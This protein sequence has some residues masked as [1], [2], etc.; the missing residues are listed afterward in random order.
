MDSLEAF[1]RGRDLTLEAHNRG[2]PINPFKAEIIPLRMDSSIPQVWQG[3]NRSAVFFLN[4]QIVLKA[5]KQYHIPSVSLPGD[6]IL[7]ELGLANFTGTQLEREAF[8]MLQN[9]PHPNL[10]RCLDSHVVED[11]GLLDGIL[12]FER[13]EP[14]STALAESDVTRQHRW[15]IELAS[16]FSHL[17]LLGIIP[18]KACVRDL[19]LDKDGRLKLVGFGASPR[20]SYPG[21]AERGETA[22]ATHRDPMPSDEIVRKDMGRAHQRLASC[23]HYILT[24]VDPDEEAQEMGHARHGQ[25]DRIQW[26]EKVRRGEYAIAPGAEPIADILQDAWTLRTITSVE[27]RSFAEV[28]RKIRDA[29]EPFEIDDDRVLQ[30]SNNFNLKLIGETC[31]VWLEMQEREPRWMGSCEYDQ[32]VREATADYDA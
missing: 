15:A 11:P 27:A 22:K 23:L 32:A 9:S 7:L 6:R 19:G 17:E 2:S 14:L 21:A 8:G 25:T 10:V 1:E 18:T 3:F 31:R 16:A 29:L 20:R 12:L 4:E 13:L 30:L 5:Q 26:R 24:G 28:E